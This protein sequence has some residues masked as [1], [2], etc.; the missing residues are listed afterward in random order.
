MAVRSAVM[1]VGLA[2]LPLGVSLASAETVS[3]PVV[4]AA[5]Q[6]TTDARTVRGHAGPALAVHPDDENIVA[7]AEAEARTGRLD[8]TSRTTPA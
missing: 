5:V 3:F 1:I 2:T 7:L 6:V 8:S 4:D